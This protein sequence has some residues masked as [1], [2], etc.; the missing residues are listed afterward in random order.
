MAIVVDVGI[1]ICPLGRAGKF[2][3][4]EVEADKFA[5][6]VQKH[7]YEYGLRQ[8]L[9]D[10]MADKKDE[11]GNVVAIPQLV[12]MAQKRLDVLYS[13]ELRSRREEDFVDPTTS[14]A[15]KLLRAKLHE[16]YNAA[17]LYKSVPKGT[18]DRTLFVLNAGLKAKK[19]PP[20]ESAFDAFTAILEK[21]TPLAKGI[22]VAAEK[23][24]AEKSA[25]GFNLDEL[26]L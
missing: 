5:P 24:A 17:G 26:G 14:E 25:V 10:A 22:W 6:N 19:L 3:K 15:F 4:L 8:I 12:A 11:D 9:N 23:I 18:K 2:G 20:F 7:I 21:K 16:G 1:Y 13:G